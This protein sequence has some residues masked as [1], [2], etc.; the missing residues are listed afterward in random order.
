MLRKEAGLSWM[1]MNLTIRCF[2]TNI[3]VV[4]YCLY[5]Q[6]SKTLGPVYLSLEWINQFGPLLEPDWFIHCCL[7]TCLP[8]HTSHFCLLLFLCLEYPFS[9][10]DFD[11]AWL[12]IHRLSL[13][14]LAC[15]PPCGTCPSYYWIGACC[16]ILCVCSL[17][18]R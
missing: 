18:S 7:T 17:S 4:P 3:L 8:Q 14:R 9:F 13:Y 16:F 15:E 11:S 1:G 6:N 10:T 5:D 12:T 2:H